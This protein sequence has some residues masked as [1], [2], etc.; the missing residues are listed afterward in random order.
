PNPP[1]HRR[2]TRGI[3]TPTPTLPRRGGGSKEKNPTSLRQSGRSFLAALAVFFGEPATAWIPSRPQADP[4]IGASGR[5]SLPPHFRKSIVEFLQ[6]EGELVLIVVAP[7]ALDNRHDFRDIAGQ[8]PLF[9]RQ[10]MRGVHR[11]IAQ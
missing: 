5:W 11:K 6:Q 8:H 7:H 10:H 9:D 3:V 4:Q 1:R 2:G